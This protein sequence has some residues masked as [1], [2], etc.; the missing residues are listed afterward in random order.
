MDNLF[1]QMIP[2]V[3]GL[4]N[5]KVAIYDCP[6]DPKAGKIDDVSDTDGIAVTNCPTSK[7]FPKGVFVVQDGINSGGNQNFKLYAWEDIAGT[8][9]IVDPSCSPRAN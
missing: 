5:T 8:R 2:N 1:K 3:N 9:L 6:A 7:Q 4:A